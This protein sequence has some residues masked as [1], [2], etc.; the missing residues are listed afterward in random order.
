[1][2]SSSD[3]QALVVIDKR[4]SEL[5]HPIRRGMCSGNP[6]H[7]DRLDAVASSPNWPDLRNNEISCPMNKFQ[8]TRSRTLIEPHYGPQSAVSSSHQRFLPESCL[9]QLD[10]VECCQKGV[11]RCSV[12]DNVSKR[13]TVPLA[14]SPHIQLTILPVFQPPTHPK[15]R[16][17]DSYGP[18]MA[19]SSTLPCFLRRTRCCVLDMSRRRRSNAVHVKRS[20]TNVDAKTNT[21]CSSPQ[22]QDRRNFEYP[23]VAIAQAPDKRGRREEDNEESGFRCLDDGGPCPSN[24]QRCSVKG[25]IS[26][27]RLVPVAPPPAE[28]TRYSPCSQ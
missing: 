23:L 9:R 7:S 4:D 27:R 11:S 21:R 14:W 6:R 18:Q 8:P 3:P 15:M 19:V 28:S 20:T 12:K 25:A 26:E 5:I 16:N 22:P 10:D 1:L 2:T 13:R 24:E 17:N